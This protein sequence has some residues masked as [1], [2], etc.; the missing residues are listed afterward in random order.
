MRI[1]SFNVL[2][3]FALAG[4]AILVS[5]AV[6]AAL[7][8][9]GKAGERYSPLNHFISELGEV[10]VSRGAAVFNYG[11]IAASV[12]L[13]PFFAGL[14]VQLDTIMGWAAALAGMTATVYCGL[15]GVYPMNNLKPHT[16]VA[17]GYF[18]FGMLTL[19]LFGI[20]LLVQ[21]RGSAAL[22]RFLG[23][24]ALAATMPYAAFMAE[25]YRVQVRAA[26]LAEAE[27]RP[28]SQEALDPDWQGE[29]P[30]LWLMPTLEWMVLI[31]TSL[32]FVLA[33]FAA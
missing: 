27:E 19:L 2:R 12:I 18:R 29:R 3:W 21:P 8:Y 9:R 26:A 33:A 14:A 1:I 6:A 22:P 30:H 32:W 4:C 5:S 24:V 10:G 28:M 13:L 16:R 23:I 15:V 31:M 17:M 25:G 7:L 11:L 20:A